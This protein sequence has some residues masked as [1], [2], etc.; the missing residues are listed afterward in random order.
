MSASVRNRLW[1]LLTPEFGMATRLLPALGFCYN[2]VRGERHKTV[3]CPSVSLAVPSIDSSSGG[4]F[5]AE[6]GRE[7]TADIDL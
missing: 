2:A 4:G 5:A 6:V 7:P 3:E 1:H